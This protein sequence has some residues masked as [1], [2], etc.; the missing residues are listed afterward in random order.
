MSLEASVQGTSAKCA[1]MTSVILE[2]APHEMQTELHSSLPLTPRLPI[3]GEPNECKQEA[4]DSVVMAGHTN[5]MVKMAE[6]RIMDVDRTT[7]LGRELAER[8]SGVDEGDRDHENE[9][10]IQQT[11]FSCEESHQHSGIMKEDVPSVQK[12]PLEGKWTVCMSGELLTTTVKPYVEDVDMNAHVCLGATCWHAN[13]VSRPGGRTDGSEGLT[14]V[15]EGLT[16]VSRGLVDGLQELTDPSHESKRAE[17]AMLGCGDRSSM[18]LGPGDAKHLVNETDG[19]GIHADRSTGQMDT[20]SVE[21]NVIKPANKS[22]TVRLPRKKR[23][24]PDLPVEAA[25]CTP[26]GSDGLRDH[27]DASSVYMDMHSIGDKTETAGNQVRNVRKHQIEQKTQNSP[28]MNGTTMPK[29][30]D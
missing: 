15:S 10:R 25:R 4:A 7:L 12:L 14:D 29:P 1:K 24:P 8:V 26:G 17:T 13:D 5:W 21:T 16:D 11:E 22:E 28:D 19:T 20:P 9:L 30:P 18:Y 23:K 2:S 6:P 27:A 3:D